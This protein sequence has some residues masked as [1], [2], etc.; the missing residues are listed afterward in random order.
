VTTGTRERDEAR[1]SDVAVLAMRILPRLML[2]IAPSAAADSVTAYRELA[3]G[4]SFRVAELFVKTRDER[5]AR[6]KSRP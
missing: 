6:I 4:E 1:E 3:I 2:P 5:L